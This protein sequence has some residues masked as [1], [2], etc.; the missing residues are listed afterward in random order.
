MLGFN[1]GQTTGVDI[2]EDSVKFAVVETSSGKIRDTWN[3][4]AL[5]DRQS[6]D[7][8]PEKIDL[9]RCIKS[10]VNQITREKTYFRRAVNASIHGGGTVSHYLELPELK[11]KELETAVPSKAVDYIPYPMDE[12]TLSFLQVPPFDGG[13]KKSAVFFVAEKNESV[14]F[15]KDLLKS[16]GI[17]LNHVETPILSLL[18]EYTRN[19]RISRG[20]IVA[21]VHVGFK[22]TLCVIVRDKNPYFAREFSL[23]GRNFT[24][25]IQMGCQC[26]WK[27]AEERK[28]Q[29]DAFS[30]DVYMEPFLIHWCEEVKRSLEF[31]RMQFSSEH[32]SVDRIYLSGGTAGMKNLDRRL[33]EEMNIP[34]CTDSWEILKLHK[35][36]HDGKNSHLY[37]VSIGLALK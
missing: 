5:P 16:C 36:S 12:I 9:V 1:T 29:Y 35:N 20:Q 17:T 13:H 11:P 26:S 32:L 19:H 8:M 24:Y 14:Q 22:L 7:E 25:A 4:Q 27:E 31:F 28:L 30:K 15:I 18:Q 37:N 3:C 6:R 21:L 33:E 2:G 23:A 10:A 34:V